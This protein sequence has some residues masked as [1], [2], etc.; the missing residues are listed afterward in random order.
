M[1]LLLLEEKDFIGP[2]K[3]VV[4]GRRFDHIKKVLKAKT[5]SQLSCGVVNGKMGTAC[6]SSFNADCLEMELR[7]DAAPPNP[8]PLILVLALPRP[9]MLKRIMESVTSLGVKEIYLMNSWRVEKSFWKSPVLEKASL[10]KYFRLGLEQGKDTMMP[11]LYQKRFFSKFVREELPVIGK[12]SLCLT[13]HPKTSAVCPAGV[14]KKT[15]LVIGPEG[16][17]ID[18]EVNT[19]EKAGFE[20]VS[21]GER[22]LK[23]ETATTYLIS[24]L[25]T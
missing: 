19:L 17:F 14:N 25:F 20:T 16:G 3:A 2:D 23:V 13:A 15:T 6:I 9:K 4:S 11:T 5:G 10:E 21:I 8:L 7:L 18:L 22:I 1:N 12:D 24:R